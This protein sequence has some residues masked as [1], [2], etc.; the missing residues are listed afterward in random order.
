[1]ITI[2]LTGSIGMGKSTILKIFNT[3]GVATWDADATVKKIYRKNGPANLAVSKLLPQAV[4]N[5]V[6]DLSYLRETII[7]NPKILLKLNAIIHPFIVDARKHFSEKKKHENTELCVFDIPLLFET[8]QESNFDYIIVATIDENTQKQ[9]V[10]ARPNMT[11]AL[12]QILKAQQIPDRQKCQHADF[13]IE[14]KSFSSVKK[15]VKEIISIIKIQ[16]SVKYNA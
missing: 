9:R 4:K 6:I 5:D 8:D 12:F 15:R 14:T 11:P 3:F 7:L 10:L 13:L 16:K 1:M 2:G